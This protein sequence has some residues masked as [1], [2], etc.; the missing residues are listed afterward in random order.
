M[1]CKGSNPNSRLNSFLCLSSGWGHSLK[2]LSN[3]VH[4][5]PLVSKASN[6]SYQVFLRNRRKLTIPFPG[7]DVECGDGTASFWG[8]DLG[9]DHRQK[10][11]PCFLSLICSQILHLAFSPIHFQ[12]FSGAHREDDGDYRTRLVETYSQIVYDSRPRVF[13]SARRMN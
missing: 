7:F 8:A 6:M 3:K 12:G 1:T 4:N 10:G 9:P 13:Q 11:L 2:K 5:T